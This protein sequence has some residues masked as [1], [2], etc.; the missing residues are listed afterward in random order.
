MSTFYLLPPR[1]V[2]GDRLADVLAG[3][4]P[5]ASWDVAA[6]ARLAEVLLEALEGSVNGFVVPREDLPPGEPAESALVDGYGAAPG[7]E[8]VEVRAAARP[9]EFSSRRWPIRSGAAGLRA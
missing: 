9:G 6:R 8:V 7:D 5:G 4:L 3:L 2:L 1:A